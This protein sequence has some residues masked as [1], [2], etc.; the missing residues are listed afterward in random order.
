[1][2]DA[3]WKC[4][5][6]GDLHLQFKVLR[7]CDCCVSWEQRRWWG[8]VLLVLHQKL[9]LPVH[10]Q[11]QLQPNPPHLPVLEKQSLDSLKRSPYQGMW[12]G[13]G[14]SQ[15]ILHRAWVQLKSH[16]Y[17]GCDGKY[18]LTASCSAGSSSWAP[19]L[20]LVP[21]APVPN[22]T[23]SCAVLT[24][25]AG[26]PSPPELQW[27]TQSWNIL[28]LLDSCPR[29]SAEEQP[30]EFQLD[31]KVWLNLIWLV[32]ENTVCCPDA[33]E[34][35]RKQLEPLQEEMLRFC[36]IQGITLH[37]RAPKNPKAIKGHGPHQ[38]WHCSSRICTLYFC[39]MLHRM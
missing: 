24:A 26:C 20:L 9:Q 1:M 27:L 39:W 2:K 18:E 34:Y 17:G 13:K 31:D 36:H 7:S 4:S 38:W 19:W 8:W 5:F 37:S 30:A 32:S 14:L 29:I 35:S 11:G 23:L 28:V 6:G 16:W 12:R 21:S 15:K 25:C 22:G 33:K 3:A 10:D